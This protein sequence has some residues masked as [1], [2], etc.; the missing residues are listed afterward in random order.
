MLLRA[1]HP[2][3]AGGISGTGRTGRTGSTGG[4]GCPAPGMPA[5]HGQL[6]PA[7]HLQT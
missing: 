5:G 3:L 4:T 1:E 6:H 7:P 2:G